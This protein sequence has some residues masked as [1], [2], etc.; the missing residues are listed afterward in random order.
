MKICIAQTASSRGKVQ[1][2]IQNHL[3]MTRSAIK[4]NSDLI[5]F[6]ELSITNYE[7]NLAKELASEIQNSIFNPFQDLADNHEISIGIGMPTNASAGINISMFIFQPNTERIVYS[8]QILHSDELAYFVCGNEQTILNLKG[9]KIAIGICYESLQREHFLNTYQKGVDIYI[10]SVAKPKAG[11]EKAYKY[12]P[13]I[14]NKFKTP[15]LMANSVGPCD[16]FMSLGQSAI[17]NQKGELVEKLNSENQGLLIYDTTY[18]LA[19]IDQ[20]K[21]VKGQLKDLEELF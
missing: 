18:E 4:L 11:I 1:E 9:K 8:K 17:W 10:A 7:P 16:N 6:P 19:E 2:N 21:I 15:I 13:E 3:R 12:F 5:I 20:T 14:A